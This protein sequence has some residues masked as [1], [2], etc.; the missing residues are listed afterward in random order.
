MC[1][2]ASVCLEGSMVFGSTDLNKI[3]KDYYNTKIIS[4]AMDKRILNVKE[5]YLYLL[6]DGRVVLYLG[7]DSQDHL[8]FYIICDFIL[9]SGDGNIRL[10]NSELQL[11][12]LDTAIHSM[13]SYTVNT[14][15]LIDRVSMP[16]I[17]FEFSKHD[18]IINNW[19]DWYKLS[20]KMIPE[21]PCLVELE[22]EQ[23]GN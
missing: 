1:L 14:F 19:K 4:G 10:P 12:L 17:I 9:I 18:Y 15:T 3:P 13:F 21:L 22:D 16:F 20:M 23:D 2:G 7:Y 8:I 5:G 6:K 11:E